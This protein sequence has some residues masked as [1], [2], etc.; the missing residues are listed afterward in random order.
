VEGWA[1]LA[2]AEVLAFIL[3]VLAA[4][5]S[6]LFQPRVF[7]GPT[8]SSGFLDFSGLA[9]WGLWL[10][11][12]LSVAS[13]LLFIWIGRSGVN[14]RLWAG[15]SVSVVLVLFNV[16]WGVPHPDNWL[17]GRT[18]ETG[19]VALVQTEVRRFR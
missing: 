17:R 9:F 2:M 15:L 18:R 7:F 14:W 6:Y 10:A 13:S 1:S 8:Y 3:L 16:G 11:L 12:A 4:A 19:I 5:A